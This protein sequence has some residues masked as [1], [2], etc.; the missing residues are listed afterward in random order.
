MTTTDILR[1]K[2]GVCRQFVKIFSEMCAHAGLR[3]K[4]IRGYVKGFSQGKL[5]M[6]CA[7]QYSDNLITYVPSK[8]RASLEVNKVS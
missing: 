1:E 6:Q 8:G 3:A 2:V 5:S 7:I 4:N